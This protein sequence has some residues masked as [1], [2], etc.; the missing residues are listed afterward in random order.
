VLRGKLGD[1][2]GK[3]MELNE[4]GH[5]VMFEGAQGTLLDLIFG[6]TRT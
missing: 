5:S 4:A 2:G 3:V 6:P 1:V